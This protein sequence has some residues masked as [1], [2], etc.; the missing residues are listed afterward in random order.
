MR[1][2]EQ[3]RTAVRLTLNYYSNIWRCNLG[4]SGTQ[5]IRFAPHIEQ[6]HKRI[7]DESGHV[8]PS[9]SIFR[10]MNEAFDKSP[11]KAY[12]RYD[13]DDAFFGRVPGDA[14]RTYEVRNFPSLYDMFGKFMA[15]LDVHVLWSDVYEDAVHGPELAAAV[16]AQSELLDNEVKTKVLPSFLAGMRDINAI[17]STTFVIGKAIIADGQVRTMNEFQSRL[18]LSTIELSSQ[19][20]RTHLDWNKSVMAVYADM[21]KLYYATRL[22]VDTKQL[23]YAAADVL[24]NMNVF[25]EPRAMLGVLNGAAAGTQKNKPSQATSAIAG[26]VSGAAAG[27]AVMPGYGTAVGAVL[28]L[29]ASFLQ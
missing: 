22:D 28:G 8:V 1:G 10:V 5:T 2:S 13:I 20:W 17:Q 21:T 23:E 9:R 11:Y 26:A 7:L 15:G 24:W 29:G 6:A 25:D 27:T 18:R 19:L 12:E 16:A 14:S 3:V 4:G